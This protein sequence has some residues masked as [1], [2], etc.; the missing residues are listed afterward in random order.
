MLNELYNLAESLS[1]AG[2]TPDEWHPQLKPLPKVSSAK[3][4]YR[5]SINDDMSVS[6]VK[7][8]DFELADGLRK[9]EPSNGSS[10]PGF[11]IQPLYRIC[12]DSKCP[13]HKDNLNIYKKWISGRAPVDIQMLK[14][15]MAHE[16]SNWDIK[17]HKRLSQCLGE[18]PQKLLQKLSED[19]NTSD[20]RHIIKIASGFIGSTEDAVASFKDALENYLFNCI[21][22]NRDI[23]IALNMLIYGGSCRKDPLGDR[24]SLSVFMDTDNFNYY[25]VAH[26]K[27]VSMINKAL[28]GNKRAE[29]CG[30]DG[31]DAFG[32]DFDRS[33]EKLAGVKLP[34][35]AEVK[36]RAMNSE[37]PCQKRYGFIDAASYPIGKTAR[38]RIKGALEWLSKPELEGKT[39]GRT[40]N[41]KELLF[42]YPKQLSS[43]PVGLAQAFGVRNLSDAPARF[44]DAV[45]DVIGLL[46]GI[47][48]DLANI[49]IEV[50]ALKKMD[51]ARTKVV[52]YRDYTA[53][54]LAEAAENWQIGA[55]NIPDIS[56]RVWGSEKGNIEKTEIPVPFPLEAAPVINKIWRQDGDLLKY[57]PVINPCDGV[58]L[59]LNENPEKQASNLLAK[60]IQNA[61]GLLISHK[62]GLRTGQ[63]MSLQ[64][65]RDK[66]L[67]LP[68]IGILLSKIGINKE[69]YMH[70]PSF[71]VGQMLRIADEIHELYCKDV[72][73]SAMPGQLIGNSMMTAALNSPVQALAQL[74]LRIKPYYGWAQTNKNEKTAGLS[75]YLI[76]LCGTTAEELSKYELP[77]RLNDAEKAQL[78][79]GYLAS[80]TTKKETEIS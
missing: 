13:D 9:W 34:Y 28:I 70:Q 51:K 14:S 44:S 23:E 46:R 39:W 43:V 78:L 56:L 24:G 10:F 29:S 77:Q 26:V 20:L 80:H 45:A 4:C 16:N 48:C 36:L 11:N 65:D 17:V 63:I 79:L 69:E 75:R 22:E 73:N 21:S 6:S 71:L 58:E 25:P 40:D 19:E 62:Y 5:I 12:M 42:A 49:E 52:F 67:I 55:A 33:D 54:R 15:W 35:V 32:G 8:V 2:I 72:R 27:T 30:A 3:P 41:T 37:S 66:I 57:I 76:K 60:L 47:S 50:F 7:P 18:I 68:L 1:L 38:I 53:H 59:M 74:G 31:L 61:K 64:K